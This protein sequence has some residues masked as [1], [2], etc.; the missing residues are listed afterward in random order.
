MIHEKIVSV[1]E[2][3]QLMKNGLKN[4]FEQSIRDLRRDKSTYTNILD[5]A[6]KDT[7]TT[8]IA[9]TY[10]GATLISSARLLCPTSGRCEIN[11]VYTNPAYRGQGYAV[12]SIKKLTKKAKTEY[13]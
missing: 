4:S 12:K 9:L 6:N 2:F 3:A 10:D 7:R 13:I 1:A 5:E 11:M 8:K